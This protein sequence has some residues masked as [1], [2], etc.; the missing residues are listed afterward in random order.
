MYLFENLI[1]SEYNDINAKYYIQFWG[2]HNLPN[3]RTQSKDPN[4]RTSEQNNPSL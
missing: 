1:K 2:A 3:S 4:L